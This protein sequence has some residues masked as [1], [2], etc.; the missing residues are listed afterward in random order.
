VEDEAPVLRLVADTLRG[1]GYTVL[2]TADSAKALE[3]AKG[4]NLHVD[5]LLTDVMM[6]RVNGYDLADAW[7]ILH[8]DLKVLFMSGHHKEVS[9]ADRKVFGLEEQLL[10]KPFSGVTLTRTVREVLDDRAR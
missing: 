10:L 5:L 7:R 3:M 8:P 6:P 9:A 1:S 4:E 2:E